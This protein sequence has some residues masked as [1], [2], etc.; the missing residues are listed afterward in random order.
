LAFTRTWPHGSP[1]TF[2]GTPSAI[3]RIRPHAEEKGR[4]PARLFYKHG[5]A[6]AQEMGNAHRRCT[7]LRIHPSAWPP[8]YSTIHT[9]LR[10][11]CTRL[12]W[13][14]EGLTRDDVLDNITLYWL[15]NRLSLRLV[16]T[17]RTSWLFC[18]RTLRS[19]CRERL[20]DEIYAVPKSWQS[21]RTQAHPLHKLDKAALCGLGTAATLC[22]EEGSRDSDPCAHS[23][24]A[25]AAAM[26]ALEAFMVAAPPG[27]DVRLKRR[28][29][30]AGILDQLTV[31]PERFEIGLSANVRSW[32]TGEGDQPRNRGHVLRQRTSACDAD[33]GRTQRHFNRGAPL[34]AAAPSDGATARGSSHSWKAASSVSNGPTCWRNAASLL[35][36]SLDRLGLGRVVLAT[37][38]SAKPTRRN[39]GWPRHPHDHARIVALRPISG[40]MNSAICMRHEAEQ[41][42]AGKSGAPPPHLASERSKEG[43]G[44]SLTYRICAGSCSLKISRR[45]F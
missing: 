36:P 3:R 20:P 19:G 21:G 9:Q 22:S 34:F 23:G 29:L 38:A 17:G 45:F 8:G 39:A 5:V 24:G 26:G 35:S 15:T 40:I 44:R 27:S 33:V 12:R 30:G 25:S 43:A 13:Q 32:H 28:Q 2:E 16:C 7:G 14:S 11:H 42:P 18:P 37:Q 6:Y 4:G 10:T 41:T 31:P 1:L